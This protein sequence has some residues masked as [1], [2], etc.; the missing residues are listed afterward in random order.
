M[1]ALYAGE[2]S[3][4]GNTYSL[5]VRVQTGTA[6]QEINVVVPQQAEN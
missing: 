2:A 4:K 5:L 6:T 3:R 1:R